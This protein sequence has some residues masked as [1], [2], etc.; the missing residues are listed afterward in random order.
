MAFATTVPEALIHGFDS[1]NVVRYPRLDTVLMVEDFVCNHSGEF[2]KKKLWEHLPRK[3]MY[4]TYCTILNYLE[5][6]GKIAFDAKN[7][8][9]WVWNPR[10]VAKYLRRPDLGR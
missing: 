9:A 8:V 4:Q 6:S 3:T 10:L 5:S 1:R 2:Q 7:R